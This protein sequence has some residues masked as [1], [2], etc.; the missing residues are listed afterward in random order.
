MARLLIHTRRTFAN[1][2]RIRGYDP[3]GFASAGGGYSTDTYD[4]YL[5]YGNVPCTRRRRFLATF[6]YETSRHSGN[7]M[8]DQALSGWDRRAC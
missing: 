1:K 5:D 8:L 3:I 6:L 7:H 4:P 2:V